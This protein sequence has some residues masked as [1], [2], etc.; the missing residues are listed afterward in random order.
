VNEAQSAVI[1]LY[2]K[3]LKLPAVRQVYRELAKDA[4]E[5]NKSYTAFLAACLAFEVEARNANQKQRR[6]KAARFPWVKSFGDFD[7]TV[8]PSL[9]KQKFWLW[10]AAVSSGNEKM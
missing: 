6:L 8:M 1:E 7:F 9:P 4:A 5:G 3:Q 2:C 10:P